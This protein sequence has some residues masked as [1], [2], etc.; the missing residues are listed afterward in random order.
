[1]KQNKSFRS[2]QRTHIIHRDSLNAWENFYRV[3]GREQRERVIDPAEIIRILNITKNDCVLQI[4]CGTG[5]HIPG[6]LK[7]LP[8]IMSLGIDFSRTAIERRTTNNILR[9]DI[10]FLPFKNFTFTKVFGFGVIEHVP[11]TKL[12]VSE[13]ARIS[14]TGAKIYLTVPNKISFF[15]LYKI[16]LM[17]LDR[18]RLRRKKFWNLG[19]EKSFTLGESVNLIRKGGF[20]ILK[21]NISPSGSANLY[22]PFINRSVFIHTLDYVLNKIQK[23]MF[24]F[25]I[26]IK[27]EKI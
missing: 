12:V 5:D 15:H 9:A 24:G 2:K 13:I 11:E 18:L 25:F 19:C 10:R 6:I 22:N 14:K 21:Y 7:E 4:G 8:G 27:A 16:F 20:K 23:N 1:M 17:T 3:R 26:K